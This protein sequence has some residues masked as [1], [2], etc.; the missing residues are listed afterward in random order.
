MP[1]EK[2]SSPRAFKHNVRTLM[3]EVGRSPHVQSR[4]Q[5]LA[6]AYATK[7]RA[8]QFGGRESPEHALLAGLG[9]GVGPSKPSAPPRAPHSLVPM[10]SIARAH[11]PHTGAHGPIHIGGIASSVPGRT[12]AHPMRVPTGAYVLPADIVSHLGQG[13]TLAGMRAAQRMFGKSYVPAR[14]IAAYARG[15]ATNESNSTQP[16]IAA[17]GE[18]VIS[19][20]AVRAWHRARGG[21][22][23]LPDAHEALDKWVVDTRAKHIATLKNLPPPAKD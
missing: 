23:A 20:G 6:I 10:R 4:A 21:S 1:L 7:R 5:A 8:R 17:G 12:D 19:P 13:N 2:S 16:I 18:F 22:G 11:K 14:G 9:P 15:G 3:H